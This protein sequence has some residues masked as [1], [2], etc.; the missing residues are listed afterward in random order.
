MECRGIRLAMPAG[1]AMTRSL[2]LLVHGAAL[3]G[4][5]TLASASV[6]P[7]DDRVDSFLGEHLLVTWY[8]NPHT[9][10][11]GV[12]GESTGAARAAALTK[13]ADAFRSVTS[14]RIVPAY[15][16]VAVVAQPAPQPGE[17]YRRR[18]SPAVIR[19]LLDEARGHGFHLVLDIQ[20]GRARVGDEVDALLPFLAEP[21]V[22]LAL[23]PEFAMGAAG[24]PGQRIGSMRASEINDAIDRLARVIAERGLP[25]KVLIVHQ[26]TLGMLPDKAQIRSHPRVEVVLM[27][28]G[29]GSQ[30]LKKSSYRAIM[31]Q[32]ELDFAGIKLFYK[33][34]RGLFSPAE[35]MELQPQPSVVIFQ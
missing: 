4:A 30:S 33:Q 8:G 25:P 15:H 14:R 16:L 27:M 21:D 17:T 6:P 2:R 34:D 19:A 24:V 28:D 23:D 32:R 7:P 31:R 12:L 11:M 5:L 9:P 10:K 26:F 3:A 13:Q 1:V 35:I 18:E 20:P 29:F 22:H